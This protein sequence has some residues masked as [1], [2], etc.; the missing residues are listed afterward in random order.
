MGAAAET[1][2][3]RLGTG[4]LILSNRIAPV[5]ASA[6]M[7]LNALAPGRIDFG[8][9]TGFTAGAPWGRSGPARRHAATVS[10]GNDAC[11]RQDRARVTCK[12]QHRST[13]VGAGNGS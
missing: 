11:F 5:A 10:V 12:D 6:L 3:I 1:S 7:S 13:G 8:V 2:R 4:V 9:S